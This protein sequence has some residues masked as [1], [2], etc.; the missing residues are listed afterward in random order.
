MRK[1][2]SG[3]LWPIA[4]LLLFLLATWAL[5]QEL[6]DY[7][8]HD[9]VRSLR[10]LSGKAVALALLFTALN[11]AVLTGYDALAL[12][13]VE[14]TLS[15]GKISLASFIGYAFSNNVGFSAIA[16]SGV[17]FRLYSAWGLSTLE[18][19]KVVVFYSVT[20]WVGLLAI[21]GATFVLEPMALPAQFHVPLATTLPLGVLLLAVLA[22]YLAAAIVLRKPLVVRGV[23]FSFPGFGVACTQTL[24][25]AVDW[26]LAAA[27]LYALLPAGG[28]LT[29]VAFLG[30]FLLA[31]FAGVVSHIPGGLG[32]FEGVLLALLGGR[33]PPD[34][35]LAALVAYR[36]IYYLLPLVLAA[37]LLGGHEALERREA[38]AKVGS[39][40]GRWVPEVAPRVI[41]LMT[42]M[43]GAVLLFSGATP[44]LF[45]RV[46]VLKGVIPL[47]V[48]EV[49]HFLGSLTGLLLLIL[50]RGLQRRL[51]AAYV[52]T[53]LLLLGGVVLSLLKGL[54]YEEAIFLLVLF[55]ALLPCRKFFYRRSSLLSPAFSPGWVVA[56]ALVFGCAVWLAFFSYKHVD[57]SHE[58]WWHF[59]FRGD[60]S[61]TMRAFVGSAVLIF[62]LAVASLMRPAPPE[63]TAPDADEIRRAASIAAGSPRTYAH[64]ALL[65]DKSLLFSESGKSFLMYGVEGRS[66]VALGGPVG[67]EDEHAELLWRFREEVD[68]FGGWPVFYEVGT[69]N[70][71]DFLDLG[72]TLL[73]VGEEARVPLDTF[74]LDGPG[75]KSLR[76]LRHRLERDGCSFEI[77]P[78][79]QVPALLP[80]LKV[81][82][83][84]W[85][86]SKSTREKAFSL[87]YFDPAYLSFFPAAIVRKEGRILAFANLLASGG[88]E[89]FSVDLMRTAAEAPSGIMDYLFIQLFLW[90]KENGYQRFNLGMAPFSGL[91][92]RALAPLW[93]KI[94]ALLF[95]TGEHYYNFQGLRQYKEKFDPVW[96]PRYI[97]CPGG[98][99]LAPILANIASLV[100][101]GL[102]GVVSK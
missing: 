60:A 96:E 53:A 63:P 18:I 22:A 56:I 11:Y 23:E 7:R 92:S 59:A 28:K 25:S 77:V 78:P 27:V 91:E 33:V 81:V 76:Y 68:L 32:V 37:V 67:P 44:E 21:G 90:G 2:F 89:E 13:Y 50:A 45:H 41:A 72:L 4:S 6:R 39:L 94:G 8:Y 70:L 36:L 87:G 51:D 52:F 42:F 83:D 26:V 57:Y 20:F 55:L 46:A 69:E 80:Q 97:A 65:G 16:G 86:A 31:Q 66:W 14:R 34:A 74:S 75:R 100:G 47:P 99:S 30:I 15:Y 88:K 84:D 19:A 48:M 5:H 10:G 102:K 93:T 98:V 9:I 61:R 71:T 95:R 1:R 38:L 40:F 3:A 29:F 73:K 12:R 17:R 58:L 49:S 35:F 79:E 24:L 85:L 62:C 43:A 101:R 64:L 54:D 82:S